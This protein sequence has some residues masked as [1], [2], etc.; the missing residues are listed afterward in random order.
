MASGFSALVVAGGIAWGW[1]T[2]V[3][4]TQGQ[5]EAG[6]QLVRSEVAGALD[7]VKL[8][9]NIIAKSE[10]A[11]MDAVIEDRPLSPAERQ[12][13]CTYWNI[14]FPKLACPQ[15]RDSRTPPED[16]G[17]AGPR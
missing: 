5:F 3:I 15:A 13:Y 4:V 9:T 8:L 12:D 7:E 14:A 6:M 1:V 11:R 10:I 17:R 16:G 2:G